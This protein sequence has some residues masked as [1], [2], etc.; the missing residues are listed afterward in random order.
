[1]PRAQARIHNRTGIGY[2]EHLRVTIASLETADPERS[3]GAA[4]ERPSEWIVWID[5]L[6]ASSR[7][8]SFYRNGS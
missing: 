6:W 5:W 3:A 1:M 2:A 4:S 8:A 7:A